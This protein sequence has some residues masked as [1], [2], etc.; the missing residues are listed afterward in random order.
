MALLKSNQIVFLLVNPLLAVLI[1]L[2]SCSSLNSGDDELTAYLFAYFTGNGPGEEA[3]HFAVSL[4]GYNYRALNNNEP[5]LNSK[6]IS[7]SGG[8]RDPHILRGRDGWFYM[9]VTDLYVPDMGWKNYAIVLLKSKDLVEWESS[10]V[11]IPETFPAEFGDVWRVWA[12]QTFYDEATGKY[13]IYFSM[14]QKNDPDI[15]YYAYANEDFTGLEAAPVQLFYSPTNNAAIDGDI[16]LKDGKYH[17]FMKSEDGEPG[18]K[19]ALSDELTRGYELLSDK[20]IDCENN[21]VEGSGIFKLNGSDEYILMYDVYTNGRYQFTKSND[22]QN[23][24]VIDESISMNFHPRH[25]TVM[26]ITEKEL[27]RLISTWG[28][29]D[30]LLIDVQSASVKK[31]NVTIDSE[32]RSIHLPVRRGTDLNAFDPEFTNWPGIKYQ[33]KGVQNFSK[34]P[35]DYTFSIGNKGDVIYSV[36]ASVDNNPVL[37]GFYADPEIM[38][39]EKTGK[40]YIYPTSDGI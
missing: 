3:V 23:F 26:P 20:R 10:R 39:A 36:S 27:N 35:V 37:E 31:Q 33:P 14:K 24:S 8:V 13:M 30:D 15:I 1:L 17:L 6:E 40:Y 7:S 4:D 21:P 9:V 18:I 38:Y 19:L 5:V 29:F 11:N 2:S 34:G 32:K 25:G 22:L 28:S 12:P 16:I